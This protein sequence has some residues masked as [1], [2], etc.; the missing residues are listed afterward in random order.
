MILKSI[1]CSFSV[2]YPP[3]LT[4]HEKNLQL[5]TN[6]QKARTRPQKAQVA[7][8]EFNMPVVRVEIV[9]EY[10]VGVIIP[11]IFYGIKIYLAFQLTIKYFTRVY[12]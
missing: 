7:T 8:K 6:I 3:L 4:L 10:S 9:T 1:L 11:N 5:R 12:E 2:A